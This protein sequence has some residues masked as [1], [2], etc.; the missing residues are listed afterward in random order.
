[1][2]VDS[3]SVVPPESQ[4]TAARLLSAVWDGAG[5]GSLAEYRQRHPRP[6]PARPG[7]PDERIV[8]LAEESGLRGRGGAGFPTGRKLRTVGSSRSVPVVVVNATEGE[9]ISHKDHLLA[10]R[11]PHLLLDGAAW[12]AAAVG[13][14]RIQVCIDRNDREAIA[15]VRA[16]LAERDRLEPGGTPVEVF[17]TP[18]RYVAGEETALVH[19]LNGGDAKP[20]MTPPRPFEKGVDGRPTLINNAETVSHL[21]LIVQHGS[22]WFRDHG[23]VDEPGTCLVTVTG[24]VGQPRVVEVP[25]GAPLTTVVQAASGLTERVGAILVGGYFGAWLPATALDTVRLSNAALRPYGAAL[26]CG[27]VH[28]LG[29]SGCGVLES[30]RVLDWFSYESAG[31]CGPCVHGLGALAA[32]MKDLALFGRADPAQLLAWA[33]DVEHRGACAMPDGAARFLRS[34]LDVFGAHID[35]HRR[36]RP[37]L[38]AEGH[39]SLPLPSRQGGPIWR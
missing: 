32:G 25:V 28:I 27:A 33:G 11:G 35:D 22:G 31:Q 17:G 24:A 5:A 1:M 3:T 16:A 34:A 6:N 7:R 37:C 9:P 2:T 18:P 30:A 39:G 4:R 8:A 21:A 38:A 15:S 10:L 20:T 26:G 12:A 13:A 36:G 14:D 19:W 29:A 23:S